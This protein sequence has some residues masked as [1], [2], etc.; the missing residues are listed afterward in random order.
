MRNG[1]AAVRAWVRRHPMLRG[2][3]RVLAAPL[4]GGASR[5]YRRLN[6]LESSRMGDALRGAWQAKQIP[7]R[8]RRIVDE[9]LAG[10]QR[11]VTVPAFEALVRLLRELVA[12]YPAGD[13]VTLVEVGCSSGYHAELL[14]TH[15]V[16][17]QYCGY[18]YSSAFIE[19]A[20]EYYPEVPF[21]V[22]DAT[23]LPLRDASVDIVLSGCCL[24][25]IPDYEAA[26]RESARI[27]RRFVIF[28]RTPVLQNA[29]TRHY[30]KRAYDVETIE[31]HFNEEEFV[32]LLARYG[33]T[34]RA[35]TTLDVAWESGASYATKEY[36]CE[37]Q[38]T[39]VTGQHVLL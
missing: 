34:I 14:Q 39:S 31:I 20:R 18:D 25:H 35:M 30:R 6:P 37:K 5:G 17:V 4:R 26:I 7:L 32:S 3:L 28:H 19:L 29:P 13:K 1:L 24:L 11:G 38:V 2:T 16:G 12:C 23:A 22:A 36:V 8:Q 27:A 10:H 33:L 15:D 9:Q 21:G